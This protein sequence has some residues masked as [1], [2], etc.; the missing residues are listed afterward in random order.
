ME[1]FGRIPNPHDVM[2]IVKNVYVGYSTN[3]DIRHMGSS[4][5]LVTELLLFLLRKGFIEQALVCGMNEKKPLEPKI[6]LA[7]TEEDIIASAQSKYVIAP[8]MRLLG[9][10]MRSKA[11]TAIVGLP[12]HIHAF[13]KMES[14]RKKRIENVK[15]IIGLACNRTLEID[16]V[17]EL[18]ELE[19]IKQS[20]IKRFKYRSGNTWPGGVCVILNDGKKKILAQNVKDAFNYLKTLY[21]PKRCLSCIDF[22][23]EFS[24]ISVMDPWI[25]DEAGN[26]LYAQHYSMAFA[27]NNRAES[28][29]HQAVE[30]GSLHLENILQKMQINKAEMIERS[31]FKY[32]LKLKKRIVPARI[33]R[34]K[35]LGR[36]Y[37][38]YN[39]DFP[40]PSL[41][42]QLLDRLGFI[43]RVPGKWK[44]SRNMYLRV[45][46]SNFGTWLMEFRNHY[47]KKKVTLRMKF[48][49]R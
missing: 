41:K 2:G 44:W 9:E 31:Q 15:L 45:A 20:T 24:D 17:P 47:K 38:Q 35:R 30:A 49:G 14:W 33:N 36:A 3:P 11:K 13:R 40:S 42:D 5:G 43:S 7:R 4:G 28:I 29:L 25:R 48:R 34:Y 32:S 18:L 6:Y 21:T 10:I 16:A 19:K 27:R 46:F 22:S 12:C 37:P 1:Q 23:A 8:Q 26:Y 39:V